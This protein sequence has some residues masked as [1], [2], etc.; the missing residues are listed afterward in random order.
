MLSFPA[1]LLSTLTLTL[2]LLSC[3]ALAQ[4]GTILFCNDTGFKDCTIPVQY[5][6]NQCYHIPDSNANGDK[7]S[8]YKVRTVLCSVVVL[9]AL[10]W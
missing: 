5:D 3:P 10:V 9:I 6:W 8:S 7:V 4:D 1:T 2:T